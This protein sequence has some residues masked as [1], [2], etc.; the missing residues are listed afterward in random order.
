[1]RLVAWLAKSFY[2]NQWWNFIDKTARNKLLGNFD[3]IHLIQE[4]AFENVISKMVPILSGAQCV[5]YVRYYFSIPLSKTHY[6]NKRVPRSELC[7][8]ITYLWC[9]YSAAAAGRIFYLW[10]ASR[11]E[12]NVIMLLILGVYWILV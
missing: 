12:K 3:R 4:K 1:M 10:Q 2:L 9:P 5:N 7:Q 6:M 11:V 8:T